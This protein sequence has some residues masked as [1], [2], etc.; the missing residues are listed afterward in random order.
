MTSARPYVVGFAAETRNVEEYAQQKRQQ[1]NLD[2]ICAND[3]SGTGQGFNSDNNALHLFW[4]GGEK[5]L[6]L[7]EKKLLGQQLLDEIILL[8]DEKNRY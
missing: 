7:N 6:P 4:Q 5:I 8:Y 1:K 3:V 2:L